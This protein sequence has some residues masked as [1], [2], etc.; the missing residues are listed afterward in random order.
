MSVKKRSE[1]NGFTLIEMLGVLAIVAIL[2]GLLA[3]QFIKHINVSI[4]DE[5]AQNLESIGQGID[6]YLRENRAWPANLAALSPDYVPISSGQITQNERGFPRYYIVHPDMSSFDNSIGIAPGGLPDAR[7]LV[8]SNLTADANPVINNS[9]QFDTWWNTDETST[10]D[11]K[12]FRGHVATLFR[13]V[14]LSAVGDGG[15]Y[16][17]DGTT[18]NSGGNR[19][20]SHGNYHI[21][22][23]PVELDEANNFSAG[24]YEFDFTLTSDSGY[25]F[26]PDCSAGFQW[27][28]LGTSCSL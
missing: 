18:T 19:L 3:P 21:V 23:T 7:F 11:L 17:I 25:Q 5:E 28:I 20:A 22:G 13:L 4:R 1:K 6:V 24:N 8:I 10:P 27:N 9:N 2:G 26:D 15:S 16:R 12:I 14:S